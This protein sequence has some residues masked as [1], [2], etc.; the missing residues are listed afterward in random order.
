MTRLT[1]RSQSELS[2]VVIGSGG[3]RA[4]AYRLEPRDPGVCALTGGSLGIC[5]EDWEHRRKLLTAG[6]PR[7]Q[8]ATSRFTPCRHPRM[9]QH[10]VEHL[11]GAARL[12]G[13]CLQMELLRLSTRPSHPY[14]YA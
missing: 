3:I 14:G 8:V 5:L 12:G 2:L 9:D 10:L 4:G 7:P 6:R 1:P 11:L 13:L